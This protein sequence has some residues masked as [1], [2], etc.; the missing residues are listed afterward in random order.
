MAYLRNLV[1]RCDE[2]S[3]VATA[4]LVNNRNAVIGRFCRR[5]ASRAL[6]RVQADERQRGEFAG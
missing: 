3:A 6:R 4:E 2:C 5:H 1:Q